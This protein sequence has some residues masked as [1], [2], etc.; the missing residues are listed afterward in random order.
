MLAEIRGE[1][2]AKS[3]AEKI[4]AVGAQGALA[5]LSC[6]FVFAGVWSREGLSRAQ[7]SLV[8]M[9]VLIALGLTEELGNHLQAGLA[10]GL[11]RQE[12][13]EAI[14]QAAPYAGLPAAWRAADRWRQIL[15]EHRG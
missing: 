13:D 7:R 5:E 11:S 2:A 10:N 4:G 15:G 6:D 1:A 12:I 9:G 3:M 8:T 14:I